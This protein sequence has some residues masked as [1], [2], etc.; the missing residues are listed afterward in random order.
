MAAR[1][2][3]RSYASHILSST[4]EADDALQDTFV[5][6]WQSSREATPGSLSVI[7]RN[8]CIDRLRHRR[9]GSSEPVPELHYESESR[10]MARESLEQVM[11]FIDNRLSRQNARVFK[12]YVIEQLDYA[13][14]S[15]RCDLSVEA[16]RAIVSRTR[17]LLRKRFYDN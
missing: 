7:L 11:D 15:R 8:L 1:L 17:K 5:R 6:L 3:L 9:F 2:K 10:Y 13:E 4:D 12:M 14:I 16:A